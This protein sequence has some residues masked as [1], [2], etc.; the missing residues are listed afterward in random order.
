MSK[1]IFDNDNFNWCK[2]KSEEDD[3]DDV[4]LSDDELSDTSLVE[5]EDHELAENQVMQAKKFIPEI[6][7]PDSAMR[8][9]ELKKN[10]FEVYWNRYTSFIAAPKVHFV[11]ETIFYFLFLVLF[12]YVI[13]CEFNYT[14]MVAET[15]LINKTF[16]DNSTSFYHNISSKLE[17]IMVKKVIG[18]SIAE[19]LLMFWVF[20]FIFDEV[21]QVNIFFN[22]KLIKL[23]INIQ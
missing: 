15:Q 3:D 6:A 18:P 12:S 10:I 5:N 2:C 14:G 13:L 9:E 4:D 16:L 21:H 17:P 1:S 20:S 11:Y 22:D 8:D 19:W 7:A 23:F